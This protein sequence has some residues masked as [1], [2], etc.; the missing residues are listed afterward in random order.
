[1]RLENNALSF[2]VNF[3]LGVSW[4]SVLLGAITTF[5]LFYQ[6]SFSYAILSAAIAMIPGMVGVLLLELFIT[7]KEKHAE[8]KK[9]TVLLEALLSKTDDS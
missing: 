4:A 1:M 3:L 7:T 2:I 6:D 8:L 9:Q 5:L